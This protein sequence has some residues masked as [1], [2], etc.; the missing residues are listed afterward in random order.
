MNLGRQRTYGIWEQK[1]NCE[2]GLCRTDIGPGKDLNFVPGWIAALEAA[3]LDGVR[4]AGFRQGDRG[5]FLPSA[6]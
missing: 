5:P 4:R 3:P 6:D 1:L 2:Y